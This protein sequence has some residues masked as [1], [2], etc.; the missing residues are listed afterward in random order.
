MFFVPTRL[1]YSILCDA[2]YHT[3]LVKR[4][5]E[6]PNVATNSQRNG[7]AQAPNSLSQYL[8]ILESH[9]TTIQFEG[10]RLDRL[11]PIHRHI[12]FHFHNLWESPNLSRFECPYKTWLRLVGIHLKIECFPGANWRCIDSKHILEW[13]INL[14]QWSDTSF[15]VEADRRR[16]IFYASF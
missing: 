2:A 12:Q 3:R 13:K 7:G 8:G 15:R 16:R 14:A 10:R 11:V 6:H 9:S 1:E 4:L 5:W